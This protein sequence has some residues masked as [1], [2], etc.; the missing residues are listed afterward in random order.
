MFH[1]GGRLRETA[2]HRL[3][4]LG[5]RVGTLD[6]S[7][8][9]AKRMG[10]RFLR[11]MDKRSA[12][13]LREFQP[14]N[15]GNAAISSPAPRGASTSAAWSS[16]TFPT[17]STASTV[18]GTTF[19]G[20]PTST[21]S[22]SCNWKAPAAVEHIGQQAILDVGDCIL[23]DSTRP[24]TF[25]FSGNF[26]NHLSLHLPRQLMYCESRVDFDIARKL[27]AFDPMAMMLR[28]SGCQDHVDGRVRYCLGQPAESD[29]QRNAAGLCFGR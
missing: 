12:V 3:T 16:P 28:G 5:G 14:E 20:M 2:W 26:S 9:D 23:V 29:V 10:A 15:G 24:T 8:P 18:I 17:I 7:G 4:L 13:D 19:A 11:T 27:E 25:Y 21:S 22:S 6:Q 1:A